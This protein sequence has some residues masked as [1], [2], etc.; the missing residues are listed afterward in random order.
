MESGCTGSELPGTGVPTPVSD[1]QWRE[2][3]PE[4]TPLTTMASSPHPRPGL[5]S[6][7]ER[8]EDRHVLSP[9]WGRAVSPAGGH[10]PVETLKPGPERSGPR[11]RPWPWAGR[12]ALHAQ[13]ASL[14]PRLEGDL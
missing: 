1:R 7:R 5:N 10:L 11:S 8:Q 3:R 14:F 2:A 12:V 9:G 13:N 4:R 6:S